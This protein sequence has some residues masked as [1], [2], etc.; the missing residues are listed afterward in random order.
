MGE[1]VVFAAVLREWTD[2]TLSWAFWALG[3]VAAGSV[4]GKKVVSFPSTQYPGAVV[5]AG[6]DMYF[7]PD[8]PTVHYA[9][10]MYR[11]HPLPDVAM[12]IQ[13]NLQDEQVLPVV[14]RLMRNAGGSAKVQIGFLAD[15][16]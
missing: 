15:L 2:D 12:E 6:F 5:G 11:V 16:L 9:V 1:D 10:K 4:T 13:F 7:V 14:F 3:S 8:E